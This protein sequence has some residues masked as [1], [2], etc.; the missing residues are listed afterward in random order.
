MNWEWLLAA[1]CI[2]TGQ[3]ELTTALP[4]NDLMRE[5][6]CLQSY[7]SRQI[8]KT[9][10]TGG[11]IVLLSEV[12]RSTKQWRLTRP[13]YFSQHWWISWLP[14]VK[15][16]LFASAALA[17]T[18][19]LFWVFFSSRGL[20]WPEVAACG[21]TLGNLARWKARQLFQELRTKSTPGILDSGN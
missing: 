11:G 19:T 2:R 10:L 9:K 14:S 7:L 3:G 13:K 20:S 16:S 8:L 6:K 15:V 1:K 12:R 4:F 18:L 17:D 5:N 21:I